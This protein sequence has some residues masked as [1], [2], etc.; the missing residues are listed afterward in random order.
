MNANTETQ[1]ILS[2]IFKT[3]DG[4]VSIEEAP[5]SEDVKQQKDSKR[6]C[7]ILKELQDLYTEV[8]CNIDEFAETWV[9]NHMKQEFG[10]DGNAFNIWTHPENYIFDQIDFVAVLLRL[11]LERVDWELVGM[12]MKQR[13]QII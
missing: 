3:I 5:L 8:N 6:N 4:Y 13:Y 1:T 12:E 2:W 10:F 7:S 11:G 9:V